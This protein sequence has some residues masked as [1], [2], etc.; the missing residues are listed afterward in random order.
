MDLEVKEADERN[1]SGEESRESVATRG[2]VE[3]APALDHVKLEHQK[4][5]LAGYLGH[6][7]TEISRVKHCMD[8]SVEFD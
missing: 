4:N 1:E 7:S 6:V 3:E 2:E 5:S 8:N